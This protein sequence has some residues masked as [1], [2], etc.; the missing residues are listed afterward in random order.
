[1]D[2][3]QKWNRKLLQDKTFAHFKLHMRQEYSDLQDVGGLTVNNSLLTQANVVKELKEHQECMSNNLKTEFN[4][5]MMQTF[6]ALNL[7]E[8]HDNE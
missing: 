5:N 3:L 2:G 7:I 6:K 8:D 1:M 4:A